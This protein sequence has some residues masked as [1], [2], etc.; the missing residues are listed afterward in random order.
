MNIKKIILTGIAVSSFVKL[1][2]GS[3]DIPPL[4]PVIPV[5]EEMKYK[6]FLD[7]S[8]GI[9]ATDVNSYISNDPHFLSDSLDDSGLVLDVGIGYRFTPNWF[10]ELSAQRTTLEY[11]NIDNFYGSI[12]Y[13][14]SGSE[15]KPFVGFI[16]GY[17]NLKWDTAPLD[18]SNPSTEDEN[19]DG[20]FIGGSIGLEYEVSE[21]VSV[22]AQYQY[23][24]NQEEIITYING[25]VMEHKNQQNF[26]VGVRYAF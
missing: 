4:S 20:Y 21:R 16:A 3:T 22:I 14:L 2:A 25:E 10:V 12:N 11:L 13:Q 15:F 7:G 17:S 19:A 24:S 26:T 1:Y 18:N 6:F 9:G 5:A 23:L 8:I